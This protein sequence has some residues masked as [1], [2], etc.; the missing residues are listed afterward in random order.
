MIS[1]NNYDH[2]ESIGTSLLPI[3]L[4]MAYQPV[5]FNSTSYP[6]TIK[7]IEEILKYSD[8]N[9][10]PE[11]PI[12]Y[13]PNSVFKLVGYHNNFT[14]DEFD[15]VNTLRQ[16]IS[17][18]L[19]QDF[20]R[21]IKPL[22]NLL[23]Q[24][25]PFR[26]VSSIASQLSSETAISLFEIGPGAGYLGALLA[27]IDANYYSFD[28]TQSL[29]IWQN[30]L[31]SKI[32]KNKFKDTFQN[33]KFHPDPSFNNI[34]LPWWQYV[35]FLENCSLNVDIVYSNSNL[36]EMSKTALMIA[37]NIS[38]KMLENSKIGLFYYFSTGMTSQNSEQQISAAF[39][40]A[41][42]KLIFTDPFIAYIPEDTDPAGIINLFSNGI[43]R[44]DP[45]NRGGN[46][47]ANEMMSLKRS[48]APLDASLAQW[49]YGLIPPF[50]D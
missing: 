10:E 38:K 9:C 7:Y 14:H 42:F 41:G 33:N 45:S 30:Y 40:A 47:S 15:L 50:I 37:L 20:G 27:H 44:F 23:A 3:P 11:T 43:S 39:I 25:G 28:V 12:L 26:V 46:I 48:E 19:G 31:F 8:H 17:E 24:T 32:S 22:S 35:N 34:H 5:T 49:L 21:P 36:G 1:P 18:S 16:T 4:L 2:F 29:Y 13:S 6:T